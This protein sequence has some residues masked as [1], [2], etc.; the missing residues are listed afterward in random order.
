MNT[1]VIGCTGTVG[2]SV[3][4]GLL[5]KGEHVRCMSR[6]S[7][8]IKNLPREAEGSVADLDKP[9]TL[10]PAFEGVDNVFLLVPVS[11]KETV[12]GLNAV[13]AARSAGVKKIVYLSVYMPEGSDVIP[14]FNSKIPVENA[15]RESGIPFTILRP[16]N[17]FQNDRSIITIVTAYGIYPTPVGLMGLNRIDVRDIGDAAVNA[18]TQQ[19]HEGLVYDLHGPDTLTGRDM[20]RI[21]S[22]YAGREVRYAGNDL[23]AWIQHVKNIMPEWMYRDFRVMYKY[24]QDHGMIARDAE[25]EKQQILLGREPRSFDGFARELVEEWKRSL[26]CAA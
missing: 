3:T 22:K 7:D 16:N 18:L 20:A 6:S 23:D 11:R 4:M 15:V 1:L 5:N 24:F 13:A 14:H 8:K 12:E 19:G 10:A 17:F 2:S 25:L 9:V 26:A 21:Y